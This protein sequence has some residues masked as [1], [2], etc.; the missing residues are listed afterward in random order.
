MK[1]AT[2]WL[3]YLQTPSKFKKRSSKRRDIEK[4]KS[5][6]NIYINPR[7]F[8]KKYDMVAGK[9]KELRDKIYAKFQINFGS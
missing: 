3:M 7:S 6:W 4:Y 9:I 2:S 5:I 1:E 8:I